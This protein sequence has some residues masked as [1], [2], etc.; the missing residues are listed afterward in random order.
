MLTVILPCHRE[1]VRGSRVPGGRS[2][3][4]SVPTPGVVQA[5]PLMEQAPQ[6]QLGMRVCVVERDGGVPGSDRARSHGPKTRGSVV[7]AREG[8]IHEGL[9]L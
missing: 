4:G 8:I 7:V 5:S 1:V 9:R 2:R 6:V 3:R